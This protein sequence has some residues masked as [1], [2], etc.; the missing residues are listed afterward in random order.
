[1]RPSWMLTQLGEE[2][3]H[4]HAFAD[5]DRLAIMERP[6]VEQYQ[7][8]LVHIY[9]FEEPLER[10]IAGTPG[11]DR[12]LLRTHLKTPRLVEDLRALDLAVD[13]I[14]SLASYRFDVPT[15][16]GW[17]YAVH[18][19][20]LLHG[21]LYRYLKAKL[22]T[23]MQA[24]GSYL[25]A[26]EAR[27][28]VLLRQLGDALDFTA[29]ADRAEARIVSAANDAFRAQRQWYGSTVMPRRPPAARPTT[30]RR[31]A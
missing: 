19:N 3:R 30:P 29:R 20:T 26:F 24:A 7:L 13:G 15:A 9:C 23:T 8:F 4:H 25:S 1:M 17:M 21:L 11:F 10:A 27:A 28:G 16:L 31:A 18:R 5:G 22:P 6:S 12:A 14:R 2:T